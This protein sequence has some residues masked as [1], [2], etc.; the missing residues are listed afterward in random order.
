LRANKDQIRTTFDQI[1]NL[2]RTTEAVTVSPQVKALYA[3][4]IISTVNESDS[5]WSYNP[6]NIEE[7]IRVTRKMLLNVPEVLVAI[8]LSTNANFITASKFLHYGATHL[9]LWCPFEKPPFFDDQVAAPSAAE[10]VTHLGRSRG[11]A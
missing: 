9:D 10:N 11:K 1:L 8:R 3:Q 4:M 7:K 2:A 5:S 6:G